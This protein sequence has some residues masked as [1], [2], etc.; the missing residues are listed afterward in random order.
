MKLK[1]PVSWLGPSACHSPFVST[2]PYPAPSHRQLAGPK[3]TASKLE[4]R[5]RRGWRGRG[6]GGQALLG[7]TGERSHPSP[8]VCPPRRNTL[9][10]TC[11][12]RLALCL[13]ATES[14]AIPEPSC[15]SWLPASPCRFTVLFCQRLRE[16]DFCCW[17]KFKSLNPNSLMLQTVELSPTPVPKGR[18]LGGDRQAVSLP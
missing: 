11:W 10:T 4:T 8:S 1:R 13:Y 7:H 17:D 12:P 6:A 14:S 3:P 9:K 2:G 15:R 18:K 16:G 5:T